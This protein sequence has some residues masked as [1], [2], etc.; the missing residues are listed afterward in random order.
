MS[1]RTLLGIGAALAFAVAVPA[2]NGQALAQSPPG[3]GAAGGVMG[4]GGPGMGPWMMGP[5]MGPMMGG[6]GG[7]MTGPMMGGYGPGMMGWGWRTGQAEDLNLSVKDVTANMDRWLAMMGNSRLKL[8]PVAQ[9][10][11][12]TI[13]ADIVTTDKGGLVQRLEINRHN[14]FMRSVGG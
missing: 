8:G 2:V 7:M 11:A 1:Q 5:M 4:G 13:S 12:D 3:P 14:G 10:D 9:K 6:Y